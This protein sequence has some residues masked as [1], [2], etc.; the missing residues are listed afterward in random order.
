MEPVLPPFR[1]FLRSLRAQT[2]NSDG[3]PDRCLEP[4]PGEL[5]VH[6]T[7]PRPTSTRLSAEHSRSRANPFLPSP[8]PLT[9]FP[10]PAPC[11]TRKPPSSRRKRAY[12]N[13]A[14]GPFRFPPTR[15][16]PYVYHHPEGFTDETRTI[17][18]SCAIRHLPWR[19]RAAFIACISERLIDG[20]RALG[21]QRSPYIAYDDGARRRATRTRRRSILRTRKRNA[22]PRSLAESYSA[23]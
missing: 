17:A 15:A 8:E 2:H 7:A 23:T 5:Q 16:A 9:R 6:S 21:S 22:G 1:A 10:R 3:H 20:K 12:P 19:L 13:P 18:C 14:T 4:S 11:C